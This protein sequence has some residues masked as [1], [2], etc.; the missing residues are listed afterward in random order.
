[1][2]N[3]TK[4]RLRAGFIR[5][6][7]ALVFLL[8][9]SGLATAK[10]SPNDLEECRRVAKL[11]SLSTGVPENVLYAIS[12][13]ET[14]RK[15]DKRFGP[16]PWTVNMEGRGVWFDT[17]AA[18]QEFV[19]AEFA[20]G[21]RSFDVGCFQLNYKW[22]GHGFSSIEEM[23][24]PMTNALYAAKFLRELYREM[25]NWSDAAGAYHSRTPKHANKY[26]ARF[27]KIYARLSPE[28]GDKKLLAESKNGHQLEA[29]PE[30]TVGTENGFPLLHGNSLAQ[31]GMGSLFPSGTSGTAAP[32]F[33]GG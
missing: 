11:A 13:A 27:D 32:F 1:M 20:R 15:K 3:K 29:A 24:D 31:T 6:L 21:A 30:A 16:W 4:A 18:A 33:I 8:I 23:F 14:G 28:G 10:M 25:G 7:A 12:L 5:Y 17:Y 26:K 9:A 22:H 19:D 2:A